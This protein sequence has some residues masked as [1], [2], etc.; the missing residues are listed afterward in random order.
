MRVYLVPYNPDDV[1]RRVKEVGATDVKRFSGRDAEIVTVHRAQGWSRAVSRFYNDCGDY[2]GVACVDFR[3][4]ALA[5]QT[6]VVVF[7]YN[8]RS[9]LL[10]LREAILT[11]F[12]VGNQG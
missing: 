5:G 1:L 2:D 11:S 10:D 8:S 3:V 7:M 6:V 9:R 12:R 4:R